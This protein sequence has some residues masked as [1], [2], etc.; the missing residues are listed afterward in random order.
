MATAGV[1][2]VEMRARDRASREMDKVGKSFDKLVEKQK[3]QI[4]GSRSMAS[5]QAQA[6]RELKAMGVELDKQGSVADRVGAAWSKLAIGFGVAAGAVYAAKRALDAV[7]DTST[8]VNAFQ[9]AGLSIEEAQRRTSGMV[10]KTDLMRSRMALANA[11]VEITDRQ[12]GLLAVAAANMADM[13]GTTT[14][15]AM[16]RLTQSMVAGQTRGLKLLGVIVDEKAAIEEWAV[17][18]GTSAAQMT[19]TDERAA[20]LEATLTKLEARYGP[21]AVAKVQ[22]FGDAWDRIGAGLYDASLAVAEV[23]VKWADAVVHEENLKGT[24]DDLIVVL[25]SGESDVSKLT[26]AVHAYD[27]A[28]AAAGKQ[29]DRFTHVLAGNDRAL[30]AAARSTVALLD[31]QR[32]GAMAREDFSAAQADGLT[33]LKF[34]IVETARGGRTLDQWAT[35]N[36]TA[37][38]SIRERT[39][40]LRALREQEAAEDRPDPLAAAVRGLGFATPEEAETKGM[41]ALAAY[42]EAQP[43]ELLGDATGAVEEYEAALADLEDTLNT[44]GGAALVFGD[45]LGASIDAAIFEAGSFAENAQ[46]IAQATLRMIGVQATGKAAMEAAEAIA[47]LALGNIPSAV[48]HGK[49]AG[50][51]AALAVGGFGGA[52]AVGGGKKVEM[53]GAGGGRERAARSGGETAYGRGPQEQREGTIV[54][55]FGGERLHTDESIARRVEQ[56]TGRGTSSGTTRGPSMFRPRA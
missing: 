42:W 26:A 8:L 28:T 22:N 38:A 54:M 34:D 32:L 5:A 1:L 40:A 35:A 23:G 2:D 48:L 24:T 20:K 10:A 47:S 15:E 49:A 53:P 9:A 56:V 39:E 36:K 37:T 21:D 30:L 17:A 44:V 33:W 4:V 25:R 13:L 11:E 18:H 41:G 14:P 7:A 3:A 12:F 51:F 16:N 19:D 43:T 55:V 29:G 45:A 52:F 6:K 31:A 46:A 27:E 50:M